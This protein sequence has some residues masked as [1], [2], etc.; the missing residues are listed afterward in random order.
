MVSS[1]KGVYSYTHAEIYRILFVI[2]ILYK[3]EELMQTQMSICSKS[4]HV[5][6]CLYHEKQKLS[7]WLI[8]KCQWR[9]N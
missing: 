8:Y 4:E 7:K 9:H 2:E 6:I 1:P 5:C 3:V